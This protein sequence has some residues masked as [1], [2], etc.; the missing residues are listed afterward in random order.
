MLDRGTLLLS[1]TKASDAVV[2]V[3]G[4]RAMVPS[5]TPRTNPILMT[6]AS[7]PSN[8]LSAGLIGLARYANLALSEELTGP[9]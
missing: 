3:T 1:T 4:L 8:N 2:W 6:Q 7:R 5:S 9:R